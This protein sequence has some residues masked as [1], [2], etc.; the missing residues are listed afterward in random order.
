MPLT[1]T[2]PDRL[3]RGDATALLE[4]AH[5]THPRALAVARASSWG[6]DPESLLLDAYV[7]LW[8]RRADAPAAGTEGWALAEVLAYCARR[9]SVHRE[10]GRGRVALA[11]RAR[12]VVRTTAG[13]AGAVAR[14]VARMISRTIPRLLSRT[15]LRPASRLVPPSPSVGRPAS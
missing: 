5:A 2:L 10:A 11:R 12:R 7:A 6:R 14:M 1:P 4:L 8:L 13:A 3:R 15:L 9:E